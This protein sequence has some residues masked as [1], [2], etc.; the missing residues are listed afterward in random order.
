MKRGKSGFLVCVFEMKRLPG[1]PPIKRMALPLSNRESVQSSSNDTGTGISKSLHQQE[2][3][4]KT[5]GELSHSTRVDSDSQSTHRSRHERSRPLPPMITHS[6]GM[7][8]GRSL[9]LGAGW[10]HIQSSPSAPRP[11]RSPVDSDATSLAKQEPPRGPSTSLA[12]LSSARATPTLGL[13]ASAPSSRS[14]N[15]LV[16]VSNSQSMTSS[17]VIPFHTAPGHSRT[18][19]VAKRPRI[20]PVESFTVTKRGL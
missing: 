15:T 4:A 20:S 19:A 10:P 12:K 1:Q 6:T 16:T 13:Q 3:Q 8:I 17:T 9:D 11:Q 7:G 14:R 18:V 2:S 5:S